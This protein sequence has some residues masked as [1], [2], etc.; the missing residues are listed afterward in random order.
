MQILMPYLLPILLFRTP[1]VV[2]DRNI[3]QARLVILQ[4]WDLE[5]QQQPPLGTC[6]NCAFLRSAASEALRAGSAA[7]VMLGPWT[8]DAVGSGMMLAGSCLLALFHSQAGFLYMWQ[9]N[10]YQQE[11][12]VNTPA[13]PNSPMSAEKSNTNNASTS[14]SQ[15]GFSLTD[16]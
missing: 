15:R 3:I 16:C 10:E 12:E 2:W 11:I 13:L 14:N 1:S 8:K 4:M 9:K 6:Q 5:Q 7:C